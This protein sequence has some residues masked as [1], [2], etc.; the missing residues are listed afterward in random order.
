MH[1]RAC[2]A[3]R[4]GLRRRRGTRKV[5]KKFR[6][7]RR[8][9]GV[10]R[11]RTRHRRL[12]GDALASASRMAR[13]RRALCWVWWVWKL[14][15]RNDDS[16]T[17]RRRARRREE[18][19][20]AVRNRRASLWRRN[21]NANANDDTNTASRSRSR[22]AKM[23]EGARVFSALRAAMRRAGGVLDLTAFKGTPIK[24]HAAPLALCWRTRA[25]STLRRSKQVGETARLT[26]ERFEEP[27]RLRARATRAVCGVAWV[28]SQTDRTAS[29][30]STRTGSRGGR[31]DGRLFTSLWHSFVRSDTNQSGTDGFKEARSS[32]SAAASE[33]RLPP[34]HARMLAVVAAVL[35][36]CEPPALFK[37]PFNP[38]LGETAR[39]ELGFV[40]GGS[41]VS[42]LEQVSHHPPVTA[43]PRRTARRL[44]RRAAPRRR[45]RRETK[46][47]RVASKSDG[48]RGVR[49]LPPAPFPAGSRSRARCTSTSRARGR[50]A[51]RLESAAWKPWKPRVLGPCSSR[52]R[53]RAAATRRLTRTSTRT[54]S[55]NYVGFGG[56]F[57]DSARPD[58]R[59]VDAIRAVRQN[60]ARRRDRAPRLE[61]HGDHRDGVRH[62]GSRRR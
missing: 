62:T 39:H 19:D 15:H 51:C 7:K 14:H 24:W 40:Y 13:R 16:R 8:G 59:R 1:H 2:W 10:R 6:G 42:V 37:K 49:A 26:R 38:V 50:S 30:S 9:S 36:D 47:Q 53:A 5:T 11:A 32:S 58:A 20:A 17:R 21:K 52:V 54:T 12:R 48:F 34:A 22:L 61:R 35:A 43:F 33:H 23:S 57:P 31:R 3:G 45:R 29:S 44:N 60:R 27:R 18:N 46:K 4:N 28:F 41:V 56:F 55:P 25:G